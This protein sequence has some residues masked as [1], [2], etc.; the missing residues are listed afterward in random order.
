MSNTFQK[1]TDTLDLPDLEITSEIIVT[2]E[3]VEQVI[4]RSKEDQKKYDLMK[5]FENHGKEMDQFANAA[6]QAH[7]DI[8][9]IGMGSEI[10]HAPELFNAASTYL[11]I[12]VDSKTLKLEMQLKLMRLEVEKMRIEKAYG[13]NDPNQNAVDGTAIAMTRKELMDSLRQMNNENDK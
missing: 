13:N 12:A 4:A 6:Y 2:D 10:R 5:T 9:E 3:E 7:K 1:L 8:H 11:K